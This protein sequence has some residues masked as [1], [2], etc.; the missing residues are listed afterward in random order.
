MNTTK[1]CYRVDVIL[2]LLTT[3][4]FFKYNKNQ[5]NFLDDL[6]KPQHAPRS[7]GFM[8]MQLHSTI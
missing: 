7:K 2:E 1:Y 6:M 8:L 5:A 4:F 3:K